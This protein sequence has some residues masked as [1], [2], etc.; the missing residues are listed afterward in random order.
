MPNHSQY[1]YKPRFWD[2][3]KERIEKRLAELKARKEE[4]TAD[5]VKGRIS[6][7]FRNARNQTGEAKLI[8]KDANRKSNFNLLVIIL[9]LLMLSYL[10]VNVNL[11]SILEFVK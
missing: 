11:Q 3:E 2:P 7:S 6:G 9:V 1:D 8:R 5:E 10:L 4:G